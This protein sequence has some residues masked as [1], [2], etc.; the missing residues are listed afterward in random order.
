[1]KITAKARNVPA[2]VAW[3]LLPTIRLGFFKLSGGGFLAFT[4]LKFDAC[5]MWS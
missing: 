4:W 3:Y 2:Q 1:M 5:V